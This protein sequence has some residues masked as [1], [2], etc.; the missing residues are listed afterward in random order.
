LVRGFY[1]LQKDVILY[2]VILTVFF[3]MRE[4]R[5]RRASGCA[6]RSSRRKSV[7]RGCGS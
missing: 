4:F 2:A 5:V 6:R 7:R 1:E 3:A